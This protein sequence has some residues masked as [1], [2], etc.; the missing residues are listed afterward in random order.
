MLKEFMV[1]AQF[2][3]PRTIHII[4]DELLR[5]ENIGN[6]KYDDF[7]SSNDWQDIVL[8]ELGEASFEKL[9]MNTAQNT[10]DFIEHKNKL[11]IELIHVIAVLIQWYQHLKNKPDD[12]DCDGKKFGD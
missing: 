8:K 9:F 6:S 2:L 3:E 10:V 1:I 4:E 12:K 11:E 7:H 5:Q